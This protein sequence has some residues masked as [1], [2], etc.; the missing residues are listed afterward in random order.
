VIV[1]GGATGIERASVSAFSAQ[2]DK[3]LLVDANGQIPFRAAAVMTAAPL[4]QWTA[5]RGTVQLR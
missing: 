2:G 4:A 3:I 5:K 1:A